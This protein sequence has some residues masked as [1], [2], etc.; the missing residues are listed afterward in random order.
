MVHLLSI[1]QALSDDERGSIE[2]VL[3]F[4][5]GIFS[6][7][8]FGITLFAWI[9]RGR[10]ATLLIVAIAFFAFFS[11]QI[12]EILPL[13]EMHDEL[14]SSIMDFVVLALFFI[15]L[16][17]RPQRRTNRNSMYNYGR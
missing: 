6:L 11:K 5:S 12:I 9:R 1:F 15:A 2:Y 8:L 3:K 13:G 7:I 17:I 14:F 16:V 4:A 10:Q